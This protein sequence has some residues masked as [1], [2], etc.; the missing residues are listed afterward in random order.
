[1]KTINTVIRDNQL[2]IA[3]KNIYSVLIYVTLNICDIQTVNQQQFQEKD[4]HSVQPTWRFGN[5]TQNSVNEVAQIVQQ[6][7]IELSLQIT[8][9]K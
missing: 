1:M 4:D 5:K 7:I 2:S 9:R 8:P 6:L 3:P